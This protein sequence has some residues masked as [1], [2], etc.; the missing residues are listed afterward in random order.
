MN[1]FSQ[2]SKHRKID[3]GVSD[4]TEVPRAA[5]Q[6]GHD[7][8]QRE[9]GRCCELRGG[10]PSQGVIASTLRK[11]FKCSR[12]LL[13]PFQKP[14]LSWKSPGWEPLTPKCHSHHL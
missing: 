7:D 2:S 11:T 1:L 6:K 12:L 5:T 3:I 10:V 13:L 4:G 14:L 8:S 9:T